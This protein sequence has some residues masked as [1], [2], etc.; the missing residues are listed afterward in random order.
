MV[1]NSGQTLVKTCFTTSLGVKS[2]STAF[3]VAM[4]NSK[5]KL[6][7]GR[8]NDRAQQ[9][10]IRK[11]RHNL[12]KRLKEFN[13][14]YDMDIWLT[15][16]MPSGSVYTFYTKED[17]APPN[18]ADLQIQRF[19]VIRKTPADY[20]PKAERQFVVRSPPIFSLRRP[21]YYRNGGHPPDLEA[22]TSHEPAV[23]HR[24]DRKEEPRTPIDGDNQYMPSPFS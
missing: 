11:R 9:E 8:A 7:P 19:P 16:R 15:M 18:E 10:Q 20:A 3:V 13:D 21:Q 17:E 5:I 4:A 23:P 22:Q 14:R 2:I 1:E 6:A 24:N 12:F